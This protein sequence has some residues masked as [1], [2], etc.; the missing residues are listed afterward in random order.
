[1]SPE[2]WVDIM[3]DGQTAFQKYLEQNQ[4]HS[5]TRIFLQD[6]EEE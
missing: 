1:M 5:G 4:N 3:P 2:S 6:H